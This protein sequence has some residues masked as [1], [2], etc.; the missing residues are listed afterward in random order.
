MKFPIRSHHWED[1]LLAGL[2]EQRSHDGWWLQELRVGYSKAPSRSD[3]KIDAI[4]LPESPP[5]ISGPD[6]D[7]D[8]LEEAI[9]GRPVELI[10]AKSHLNVDVIGQLLCG[11]SMFSWKYPNHGRLTLTAV[12]EHADD[13]AL[14]W[15]CDVDRIDVIEV[16]PVPAE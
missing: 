14:S 10:E 13:A 4:V 7:L 16:V 11:A 15:Y 5:L 9:A 8:A 12:V 6:Q 1:R 3:R 2:W